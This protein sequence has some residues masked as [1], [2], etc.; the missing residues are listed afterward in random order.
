MTSNCA[1]LALIRKT[2]SILMNFY[3]RN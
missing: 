1:A 2:S 3:S